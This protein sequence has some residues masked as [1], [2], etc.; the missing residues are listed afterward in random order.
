MSTRKFYGLKAT[1]AI[2]AAM[3]VMSVAAT[4]NAAPNA[5]EMWAMSRIKANAASAHKESGEGAKALK[6]VTG[7][8]IKDIK[9]HGIFGGRNSFFRKPFG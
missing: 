7:V 1:V 9:K 5:A 2:A 6:T 3:F 4:A 8:S